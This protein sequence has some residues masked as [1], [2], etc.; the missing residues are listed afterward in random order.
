VGDAGDVPKKSP[1]TGSS[2]EIRRVKTGAPLKFTLGIPFH[3]VIAAQAVGADAFSEWIFRAVEKAHQAAVAQRRHA[4][5]R[6]PRDFN[7]IEPGWFITQ[8]L[9]RVPTAI[10]RR[11][12]GRP[13]LRRP[14]HWAVVHLVDVHLVIYPHACAG[15]GH[16]RSLRKSDFFLLRQAIA[17]QVGPHRGFFVARVRNRSVFRIFWN[18]SAKVRRHKRPGRV[19]GIVEVM[20]HEIL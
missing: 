1:F 14:F 3:D 2:T 18:C 7:R 4:G 15:P 12:A 10:H 5:A 16:Q 6:G 19:I 9:P 20:Q 17:V 8:R 13:I 11:A